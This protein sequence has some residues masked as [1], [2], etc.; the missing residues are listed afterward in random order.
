MAVQTT[1]HEK[2]TQ[3]GQKN[4]CAKLSP[5]SKGDASGYQ[6]M[7]G[8]EFSKGSKAW[9]SSKP[10]T[11]KRIGVIYHCWLLTFSVFKANVENISIAARLG[12]L[13]AKR[14]PPP[15]NLVT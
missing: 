3:L 6:G 10:F 15:I 5:N 9:Y 13:E 8:Y 7:H 1:R 2:G 14:T 4:L 11:P 12:P